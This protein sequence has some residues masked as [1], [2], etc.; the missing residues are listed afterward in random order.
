M[1]Q[2]PGKFKLI[3]SCV[4]VS[5]LV[6]LTYLVFESA[7]HSSINYLWQTLFKTATTRWLV[8]PLS[9]VGALV[10]FGLQHR[11][12]PKSENHESHSLGGNPITPTLRNFIT[13]LGL[14]FFSLVG[15]ASLGPEAVLVPASVLIGGALAFQVFRTSEVATKALT[16]AAT[17]ALMTAFFHSFI[18]G[19]LSVFLVMKT[20]QVRLSARLFIV[21]VVAS[22]SS[23]LTL[24]TID[25]SNQYFNFPIIT[26]R[27]ALL[28]ILGGVILIAAGYTATFAL[29]YLHKQFVQYRSRTKLKTW[30]GLALLAGF[31]LSLFYLLGGPL[32]E[33]TGNES[34]A[35]LVN[36]APTM[37]LTGL[38][39]I[40]GIKLV[41]IGWSKAMGYRGGL[42]FPMIFVASTLVVVL[43][44]YFGHLNF[45]IGLIAAM[46]GIL[47]AEG[48]AHILL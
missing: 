45:G 31:G 37:S 14:G 18:I 40:L 43:Q 25:P 44:A 30:W 1:T 3:L 5:I 24:N 33:F 41:V 39:V 17:M 27:I 46:I 38:L 9:I 4:L 7:V 34:I 15:G 36:R 22:A 10:F 21:A 16:A 28:D 11:F 8:V 13:I 42:I 29:K 20:A 6:A 2:D 47:A 32:V 35:P 19:L 48:K 26:W 12:D 23:Y